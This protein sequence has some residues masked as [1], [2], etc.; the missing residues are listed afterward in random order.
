ML[1]ILNEI[2]QLDFIHF[3]TVENG[4]TFFVILRSDVMK[5]LDERI[6]KLSVYPK[7][8]GLLSKRLSIE[9]RVKLSSIKLDA[10]RHE[11]TAG[12]S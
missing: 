12:C 2:L 5:T 1:T 6:P 3:Q 4:S 8:P 7:I 10:R 9:D 11:L